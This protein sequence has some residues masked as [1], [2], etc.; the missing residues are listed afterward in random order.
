MY[1]QFETIADSGVEEDHPEATRQSPGPRGSRRRKGKHSS[2]E[3]KSY[4]LVAPGEVDPDVHR[5]AYDLAL[6]DARV[7]LM[8]QPKKKKKVTITFYFFSA[9]CILEP[10]SEIIQTCEVNAGPPSVPSSCLW[11]SY[12]R[13]WFFGPCKQEILIFM[14]LLFVEIKSATGF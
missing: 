5:L 11:S 3:R 1:P 7:K 8:F 2:K 13:T 6:A 12:V 10:P 14:F 9:S 4:L